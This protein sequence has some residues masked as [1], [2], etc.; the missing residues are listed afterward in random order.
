MSCCHSVCSVYLVLVNAIAGIFVVAESVVALAP[1]NKLAGVEPHRPAATVTG[2]A[3]VLERAKQGFGAVVAVGNAHVLHILGQKLLVLSTTYGVEYLSVVIH[4][5]VDN[6]WPEVVAFRRQ[7]DMLGGIPAA[8]VNAEALQLL[9]V[10]LE[11]LLHARVLG[12]EVAHTDRAVSHFVAAAIIS[13]A[14]VVVEVGV[15]PV[16]GNPVERAVGVVGNNVNDDL[17]A[18]RMGRIAKCFQ[19]A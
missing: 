14:I 2:H 11:L 13:T 10:C 19:V 6:R 5:L 7:A 3:A 4:R 16:V 12:L 9:H 1:I 8:S 17:D 18:Q 15:L